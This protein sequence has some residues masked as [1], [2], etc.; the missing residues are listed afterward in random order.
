MQ[1][2]GFFQSNIRISGTQKRCA[3]PAALTCHITRGCNVHYERCA[4]VHTVKGNVPLMQIWL[5][6]KNEKS[7]LHN[8]AK[9][10]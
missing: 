3:Y 9:N 10:C 2:Y 5:T 1:I 4:E 6:Q 8:V 7:H